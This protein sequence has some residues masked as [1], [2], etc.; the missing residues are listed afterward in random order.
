MENSD[1]E[2]ARVEEKNKNIINQSKLLKKKKKR[3]ILFVG[4]LPYSYTENDIRELFSGI[5]IIS[6][7]I[8]IPKNTKNKELSKGY[9]FVEFSNSLNLQRALRFHHKEVDGR[10]INIELTAGGGGNSKIRL[11]KIQDGRRRL[12]IERQKI[13]KNYQPTN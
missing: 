5:A 2:E 4:N 10:K 11:K 8:P 7:R 3:Y 6:I 1:D 9:A 13:E 12:Q